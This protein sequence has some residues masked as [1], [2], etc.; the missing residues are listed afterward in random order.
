[1]EFEGFGFRGGVLFYY[2]PCLPFVLMFYLIGSNIWG[3]IHVISE[4]NFYASFG[5]V[6]F[7]GILF[8]F[9][10]RDFLFRIPCLV[11]VHRFLVEIL[12]RWIKKGKWVWLYDFEFEMF[13]YVWNRVRTM[14]VMGSSSSS[15]RLQNREKEKWLW[16]FTFRFHVE[17]V[18]SNIWFMGGGSVEAHLGLLTRAPVGS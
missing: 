7:C 11:G 6:F 9:H 3:V 2:Y 10:N 14:V 5:F 13:I 17:T 8:G 1:M 16:V 15:M 18:F 12:K 4:P